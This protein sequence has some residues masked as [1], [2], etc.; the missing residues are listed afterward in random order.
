MPE[1]AITVASKVLEQLK[2]LPQ[3]PVHGLKRYAASA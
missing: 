2:N 3:A 1:E